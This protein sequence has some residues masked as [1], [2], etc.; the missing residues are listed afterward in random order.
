MNKEGPSRS[1]LARFNP[2]APLAELA[3]L[4]REFFGEAPFGL[5]RSASVP[6]T[7]VY[8]KDGNLFVEAHLPNF[9]RDDVKVNV[10]DG[11]F[12]ISADRHEK[13]EH[14]DRKYV[15]RESSTSSRRG[16]SLPEGVDVS[17]IN[18]SLDDGVLTVQIPLPHAAETTSQKITIGSKAGTGT[19][20]VDEG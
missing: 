12:I 14:T 10:E 6:T 16:I 2:L 15:V 11:D 5:V 7:D 9:D 8:E 17:A 3:S 18:G 19:E 20:D 13:S 4:Q 1:Y